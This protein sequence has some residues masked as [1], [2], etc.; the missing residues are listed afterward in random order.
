METQIITI[1]VKTDLDP[2]LLH[3]IALEL[4]EQLLS[5]VESYD[6]EAEVDETEVAV[7]PAE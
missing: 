1:P 3:D 4:A 5:F 7:E 6:G 2:S